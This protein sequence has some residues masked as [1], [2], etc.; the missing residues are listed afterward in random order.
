MKAL[1]FVGLLAA[2]CGQH[3][4]SAQDTTTTTSAVVRPSD[5]TRPG[6]SPGINV[7]PE[8]MRACHIS[9]DT[10][11]TAPKFAFDAAELDGADRI[12]LAQVAKCLTDGPLAGRSIK[13]VG[14]ADPRG[15]EEYNMVLGAHRADAAERFLLDMGVKPAHVHETS[16]GK[17]DATGTDEEGWARDR[18]VDLD[19]EYF[20]NHL[21]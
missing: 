19:L 15:E 21:R 17:L 3:A 18:R 6:R 7:S 12:L 13:L 9:F 5:M 4:H 8:L 14:R 20:D 11:D 16:R 2:G 10:V 1:V